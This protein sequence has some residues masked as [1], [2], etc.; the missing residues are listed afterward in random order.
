MGMLS[1]AYNQSA[2]MSM[3]NFNGQNVNL[4]MSSIPQGATLHG[5]HICEKQDE[6]TS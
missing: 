6:T 2:N 5:E 1:A 3:Q 4:N